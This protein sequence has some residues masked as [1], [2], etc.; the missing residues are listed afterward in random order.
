MSSRLI[1]QRSAP[2]WPRSRQLVRIAL[3]HL[4]IEHVD[5]GELL[6]QAALAFHHRLAGERPDMPRPST[7]EPLVITQPGWRATSAWPLPSVVL[8]SGG[9]RRR[10]RANRRAR[11]RAG[12]QAFGRRDGDFPDVGHAMIFQCVA[13]QLLLSIICPPTSLSSRRRDSLSLPGGRQIGATRP[14][15]LP[16]SCR[17]IRT[18]WDAGGWSCDVDRIASHLHGEADLA[19]QVARMVPRCRRRA[20]GDWPHRTAVW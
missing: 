17:S 15:T 1:R 20:G 6:E 12:S 4:D 16:P 2:G 9:T 19:D 8:D 10:R 7:A 3:V 5:A 14:R 11:G 13:A 18:M